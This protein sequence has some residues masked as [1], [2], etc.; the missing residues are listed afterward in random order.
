MSLKQNDG[1]S[2]FLAVPL[3]RYIAI[4]VRKPIKLDSRISFGYMGFGF[5]FPEVEAV[6][7]V[8]PLRQLAY[9][10]YDELNHTRPEQ[11]CDPAPVEHPGTRGS[12]RASKPPQLLQRCL[13][14]F[15][16]ARFHIVTIRPFD[17]ARLLCGAEIPQ[18]K[19]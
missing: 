12:H 4:A 16:Q 6:I 1:M 8:D 10:S 7:N 11:L 15:S 2:E 3:G 18:D 14:D 9:V 19:I 13:H 5:A 17:P